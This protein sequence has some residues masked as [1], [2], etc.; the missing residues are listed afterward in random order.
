MSDGSHSRRLAAN[1]DRD[2]HAPHWSRDGKGIYFVTE[3]RGTAQLYYAGLDGSA[4]AITSGQVRFA[5]SYGT[6]D[7]FSMSDNGRVAIVRSSPTEPADVVTFPIDK[8]TQVTRLT[9]SN[10]SLLAS[11]KLGETEA[12]AYDSFDG[13]PMQGWIVKPP[14][15]N[16][17][18]K[19]AL[20]LE[21][22]GGPHAMYGVEFQEEF[23]IYAAHGF[24]VVYVNPR[25]S[26]GYGEEFGNVIHT[27]Y[28]GDDFK[29]LMAGVDAVIAKGYID[30]KRLTV[31]GG[32]GGGLLTAWAIG[33]TNRFAAAVA[34]YP[35]TN[36]FTQ[37]GTADGGY[38]HAANWMKS[39]PWD[40][41]TQYIE[42]SP[43][44]FAQNF[45]T[46]T[47][48]ITGQADRRTPIAQSE[49][50]YFALKARK[51]PAVLVEI[52][53]EP[54]G[55]RGAHPSHRI[56]KTE[57]V[58]AWIEKYTQQASAAATSSGN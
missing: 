28:P 38:M 32:S 52:P 45:A 10:D 6:S 37:V 2:V 11:H 26:T 51:V 7:S 47:M 21:I 53:D 34:Q 43:V 50:L 36:W 1:L 8:P 44:F 39:M 22:H 30:P 56:A 54:H 24:V 13:R 42:H 19:Y 29:D 46:P 15:F 9:E 14:D 35:V 55:I 20:L 23:Q 33:H 3:D 18:K 17:S 31:T 25:G 27:K 5:S 57:N 49:E 16:P 48:I 4:R 40:N 58:L 12:F 41:P